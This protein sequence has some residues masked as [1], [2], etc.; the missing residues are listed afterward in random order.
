MLTLL[1]FASSA[2]NWLTFT[3]SVAAEP[4]ATFVRRRFRLALPTDTS[5]DAVAPDSVP[6]P[7]LNAVAD[8]FAV[9]VAF[10]P[11]ATEFDAVAIAAPPIA[12]AFAPDA[13]ESARVELAWKYLMPPPWTIF[14]TWLLMFVT[15]P[16]RFVIAPAT[17]LYVVPPAMYVGAL[18]LPVVGS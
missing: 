4:A 11:N 17:L 13:V 16:S 14:V 7:G 5:P 8:R 3:A 9:V 6:L 2:I 15:R 18:M 1:T 12:T 10:E